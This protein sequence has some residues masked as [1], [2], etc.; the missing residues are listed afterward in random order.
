[1]SDSNQPLPEDNATVTPVETATWTRYLPNGLRQ[2]VQASKYR[3]CARESSLWGIASGT[4]MA[5]HRMRMGSS[6]GFSV[7][8]GFGALFTVMFGSY[9]FCVQKRDYQE[10]MIEVLMRLNEFQPADEMPET[11]TID[12]NHPFMEMSDDNTAAGKNRIQYTAQ[13]PDRKEWQAPVP[14]Q[15][16]KDVFQPVVSKPFTKGLRDSKTK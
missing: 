4:A 2:A 16:A 10:R 9:Y 3:W 12:A 5:L 6:A 8:V 15:D 1:M 14:T 7:N 13:L 11:E